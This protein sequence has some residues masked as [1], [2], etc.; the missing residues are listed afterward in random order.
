MGSEDRQ[1]KTH[2]RVQLVIILLFMIVITIVLKYG[3]TSHLDRGLFIVKEYNK[4]LEKE[5]DIHFVDQELPNIIYR[6]SH[7]TSSTSWSRWI[8]EQ[9]DEEYCIVDKVMK[10]GINLMSN[11]MEKLYECRGDKPVAILGHNLFTKKDLRSINNRTTYIIDSVREPSIIPLSACAQRLKLNEV[12]INVTECDTLKG[13]D[14]DW[15]RYPGGR[16]N[17]SVID[18]WLS[19]THQCKSFEIF[20]NIT[21]VCTNFNSELGNRNVRNIQWT[22]YDNVKIIINIKSVID[23]LAANAYI[24]DRYNEI[25]I[26]YRKF[27]CSAL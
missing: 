26:N 17:E 16:N 1:I 13:L 4:V 18:I 25:F 20:C 11:H 2:I 5:D 19:S 7:K 24:H 27:N 21:T 3:N 12:E 10:K 22:N 9:I 14:S 8:R 6:K 23:Y 15:Y